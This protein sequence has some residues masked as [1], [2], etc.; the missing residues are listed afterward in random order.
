[1]V[2]KFNFTE[3]GGLILH[4]S[5]Y[6]IVFLALSIPII[7][8]YPYEVS[9]DATTRL[10]CKRC[11]DERFNENRNFFLDYSAIKTITAPEGVKDPEACKNCKGKV[12][13]I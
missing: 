5:L 2:E 8:I 12:S 11:F 10:C 13:A 1:M 7:Q 3:K 6:T 9:L 4:K